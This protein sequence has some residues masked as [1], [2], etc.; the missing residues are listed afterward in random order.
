MFCLL[1]NPENVFLLVV[2]Y[3]LLCFAMLFFPNLLE[4]DGECRVA[5]G[6]AW[7]MFVE[8]LGS[9]FDWNIAET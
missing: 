3:V 8:N 1:N 4:E 2:C 5:S 6:G 7:G 9:M